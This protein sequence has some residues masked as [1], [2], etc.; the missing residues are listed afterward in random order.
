[1]FNLSKK[2]IVDLPAIMQSSSSI[3]PS[4]SGQ[5]Q[6]LNN[7]NVGDHAIIDHLN[8]SS[9][10]VRRRLLEMG[11]TRGTRIQIIRFAPLG[12]PIEIALRGYR[13]SLRREEAASI[14]VDKLEA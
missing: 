8:E 11:L 5:T 12:D 3:N 9:A 10:N 6:S 13:L 4:E 2:E 1:M 14:I 7:L